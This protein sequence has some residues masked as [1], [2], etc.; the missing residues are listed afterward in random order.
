MKIE[1]NGTGRV[2]LSDFYKLALDDPWRFQDSVPYLRQLGALDESNTSRPSVMILNCV[3]SPSICIE[4]SRFYSVCCVNECEGLLGYLAREIAAPQAT[5]SHIAKLIS[6]LSSSSVVA[7]R[8]LSPVLLDRL[9]EVAATHGGT[10]PLHGRLFAQWMRH[11]FPRACPFPHVSGTTNPNAEE[12]VA[13]F[14]EM[15]AHVEKS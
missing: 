13:T 9:E 10:V 5:S 8:K 14:E 2:L 4:T 6:E 15:Q 7:P 3:L 1:D 12:E 11:A